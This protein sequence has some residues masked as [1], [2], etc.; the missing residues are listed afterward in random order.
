V[1][2]ADAQDR[3][4]QLTSWDADWAGLR[5][6]VTGIG[7]S[8][9]SA[10]DTLIELGARVVVCDA[11]DSEE[12]RAKADTLHIVGAADVLLGG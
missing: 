7:L 2:N 10:A 9:F 3:L 4:D 12:N 11:T 8:G 6:V 1:S 5:V